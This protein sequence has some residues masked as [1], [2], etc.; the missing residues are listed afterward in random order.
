MSADILIVDDQEDIRALIQGILEDEGYS[1]RE[2]ADST[3]ALSAM[4]EK[5]PDLVVL[6]IWLENSEHDGMEVLKRI[7]KNDPALPV[8]MI[9]GHGNIETAVSAIQLGAYDFIEKPFKADRLLV[10]AQRAIEA[11]YLKKENQELRIK[12]SGGGAALNGSSHLISQVRQAIERVA[13][14]NSRV[15][16]TGKP[17]TGKEVAARLLHQK[18]KR[19]ESPYIVLNCAV[20]RPDHLETELFGT[21]ENNTVKYG[22]LE[23][24]NG[25]TLFLDEVSDMPME[26]Q[27]K[28]VRVLQDQH[29]TRQGGTK[30]VD[31][32]VRII[33]STN[34]RLDEM[35]E[36]GKFRQDLY[37]RLNVVPIHMPSLADRP[38]DIPELAA[39]FMKQSAQSANMPVRTLADDAI[40]IMQSYHWPGNVRQLRNI[41]EWLLIMAGDY[42]DQPITGD[43]LPPEIRQEARDVL[44]GDSGVE[45]MSKPLREA[46]EIFEREYLLSQVTRFG[47][48]ISK[49]AGFVGMERSA[50]H[51]KLKSLGIQANDKDKERAEG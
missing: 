18:S 6:D 24:A 40:A 34:Q 10:L 19:A 42:S 4:A 16:L 47:G 7:V 44:A 39:F 11:A 36:A 5:K 25:G 38:E 49:T 27:G 32:D 37:Y 20:L 21:E 31:V 13:P 51:R 3:A 1:T 8:I 30:R 2:A 12:A 48:N 43:M 29:F 17:G 46:R 26:T 41:I 22:V 33:A 9:S 23:Q 35:M 28:I 45:I 15:L 14:S 50:L